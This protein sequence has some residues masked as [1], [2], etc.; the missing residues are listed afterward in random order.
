MSLTLE[1][2]R[3]R[4]LE[5]SCITAFQ[6]RVATKKLAQ[7]NI[8]H[9]EHFRSILNHCICSTNAII[10]EKCIST[11]CELVRQELINSNSLLVMAQQLLPDASQAKEKQ[12]YCLKNFA[13]LLSRISVI[14]G[15]DSLLVDFAVGEERI[16]PFL[17]SET[18]NVTFKEFVLGN[19]E[20]IL[21]SITTSK[22]Y[23]ASR[24]V[25]L[26]NLVSCRSEKAEELL[27]MFMI[28]N[29]GRISFDEFA[30]LRPLS[31]MLSE[32]SAV[33]VDST[34]FRLFAAYLECLIDAFASFG[35]LETDLIAA[36]TE[37]TAMK[38]RF[39]ITDTNVDGLVLS[40]PML[41]KSCNRALSD[42]IIKH[43]SICS[44]FTALSSLTQLNIL[45]THG[46]D[47]DLLNQCRKVKSAGIDSEFFALPF[48]TFTGKKFDHLLKCIKSDN[49]GDL[50]FESFVE[51][52][53]FR[54]LCCDSNKL[55]VVEKLIDF[56]SSKT[57]DEESSLLHNILQLW[58]IDILEKYYNQKEIVA[59]LPSIA[60]STTTTSTVVYEFVQ[61]KLN[62]L[63]ISNS[64]NH[65]ACFAMSLFN[66]LPASE[67]RQSRLNYIT[68]SCLS[69]LSQVV[70]GSMSRVDGRN[71]LL[72]SKILVRLSS[73][74]AIDPRLVWTKYFENGLLNGNE[75]ST[76]VTLSAI[77]FIQAFK[78]IPDGNLVEF[79]NFSSNQCRQGW[80]C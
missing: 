29:S 59:L 10:V 25:L 39:S 80:K 41:V 4:E 37:F 76:A 9:N 21:K 16:V 43:S 8:L 68:A 7:Q 13:K 60:R 64:I 72:I 75:S 20:L 50:H 30:I 49:F 70:S 53:F 23:V 18:S 66:L 6:N 1:L 55:V 42:A 69:F 11:C 77:A 26:S 12:C 34:R 36:I 22:H 28:W 79:A 61:S 48:I 71:L 74:L 62:Q 56:V 44:N 5:V 45:V 46:Q 17:L 35:T 51:V 54:Q 67:S 57:V 63:D 38:I 58:L 3:L 15:S 47:Q 65:Q 31:N 33:K 32:V 19:P 27:L 24:L 52:L 73:I 2:L 40:I 78:A 14:S